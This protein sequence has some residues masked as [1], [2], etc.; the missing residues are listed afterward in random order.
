MEKLHDLRLT[1]SKSDESVLSEEDFKALLIHLSKKNK[2]KYEFIL[3][4]GG[5]FKN[6]LFTLFKKVWE[7]A[8]KPTSWRKT[9]C[10]Q[11][12]KGKGE[13]MDFSNQV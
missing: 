9:M 3:K 6:L 8:A 2:E 4:A 7:S 11:L 5:S 12:Y 1:E 13:E 10:H